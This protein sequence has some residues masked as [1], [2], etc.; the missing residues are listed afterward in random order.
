[1]FLCILYHIPNIL[2]P[3]KDEY[4]HLMNTSLFCVEACCIFSRTLE[5]NQLWNRFQC[6]YYFQGEVEEIAGD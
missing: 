4:S 5:R 1:M 6:D 2:R 3:C